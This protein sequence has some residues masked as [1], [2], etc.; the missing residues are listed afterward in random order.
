MN[1]SIP[2]D[3]IVVGERMRKEYNKIPE[4]AESISNV[5]LIHPIVVRPTP[6]GKYELI[7]GG[8]RHAAITT[9]GWTDVPVFIIPAKNLSH[10][11]LMELEENLQREDMTWKEK[12]MSIAAIH[13]EH[14]RSATLEGQDWIMA[15]TGQIFGFHRTYVG[16]ALD[17]AQAVEDGDDEVLKC[18]NVN[19]AHN[20]LL[21]RRLLELQAEKAR[22]MEAVVAAQK[23]NDIK[24]FV[25]AGSTAGKSEA[26]TTP[27]VITL[28]DDPAVKLALR[29]QR[30]MEDLIIG[31]SIEWMKQCPPYQFDHVYTDIPYGVDTEHQ[32]LKHIDV[33][34]DEH[35]REDN[36]AL[37]EPF[38]TQAVRMCR[39]FCVFWHDPEHTNLLYTIAQD[40]GFYAQRWPLIWDKRGMPIHNQ[41]AQYNTPKDYEVVMVCRQKNAT[42][43]AAVASSIFGGKWAKHEREKYLH[44][45]VKPHEAHAKVLAMFARPGQ[46]FLDPF[47]GEGSGFLAGVRLGFKP[48]GID[49]VPQH[50]FRA[51]EHYNKVLGHM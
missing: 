41:V 23:A 42:L 11:M 29:Q 33:T 35:D 12:V 18:E 14:K 48:T 19:E 9:L 7:A 27:A 30:V 34:A 17:I 20:L 3:Q 28:E 26:P 16:R 47:C 2:L 31:D 36:I 21:K 32:E 8:R 15:Q 6:E 45:Y 44:P 46:T 40:V 4:L 13:L 10:A 5:G 39:S 38:L 43:P 37:F 22:R 50:I 51:R 49:L 24:K 25:Q 1:P